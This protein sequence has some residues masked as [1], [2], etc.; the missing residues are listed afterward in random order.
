MSWV[1]GA[2]VIMTGNRSTSLDDVIDVEFT[3]WDM[4]FMATVYYLLNMH[5]CMKVPGYLGGP[6]FYRGSSDLKNSP[7]RP[8][9][10]LGQRCGD[11]ALIKML[12]QQEPLAR[13][14]SHM[15]GM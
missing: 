7:Y 13:N 14:P 4:F 10:T 15:E 5:S 1:I 11:E 6:L 9:H 3:L 2:F 12:C 8:P